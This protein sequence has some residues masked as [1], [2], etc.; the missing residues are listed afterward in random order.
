M[1][2]SLTSAPVLSGNNYLPYKVSLT[3]NI[4][5]FDVRIAEQLYSLD[6]TAVCVSIDRFLVVVL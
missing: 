2:L 3:P 6:V 4:K 5:R 1:S